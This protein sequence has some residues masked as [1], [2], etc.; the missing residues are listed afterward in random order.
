TLQS[1]ALVVQRWHIG[2]GERVSVKGSEL[3]G[4]AKLTKR[5]TICGAVTYTDAKFVRFINAPLPLEETGLTVEGVQVAFKDVSGERLP[6]I[7]KWSGSFSA[8][9]ASNKI[10]FQE[11]QGQAFFA[12]DTFF[13][14]EF[15]SS[16]SPSKYLNID[17]YGLLNLR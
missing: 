2:N 6:G 5:L 7:S 15:S 14:S 13:R 17:G 8:E 12:F 1:P 9:L 10:R 3:D 4:S 16:S 11:Q